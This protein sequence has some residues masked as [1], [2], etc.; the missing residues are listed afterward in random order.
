M[1]ITL[2]DGTLVSLEDWVDDRI[3]S[4]VLFED[5]SWRDDLSVGLDAM[6]EGQHAK[7]REIWDHLDRVHP[8]WIFQIHRVRSGK[9]PKQKLEAEARA[10]IVMMLADVT[11]Q[12][13]IAKGLG[14]SRVRVGQLVALGKRVLRRN[15]CEEMGFL[16]EDYPSAEK[17]RRQRFKALMDAGLL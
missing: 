7:A 5:Q 1:I 17:R 2:P 6:Y 3:Y 9:E 15:G 11:T 10:V 8:D 13:Q 16:E 14:L 4:A 12:V